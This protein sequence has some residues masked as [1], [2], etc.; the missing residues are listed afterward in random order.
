MRKPA[1]TLVFLICLSEAAENYDLFDVAN[2]VA[3]RELK[4]DWLKFVAKARG[5]CEDRQKIEESVSTNSF[6]NDIVK[7]KAMGVD[8]TDTHKVK[9]FVYWLAL[10]KEL[11]TEVE[12][13]K[14]LIDVSLDYTSDIKDL[15]DNFSW[16]KLCKR[17]Q[18]NL[19]KSK[20]G[21]RR[22]SQLLGP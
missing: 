20:D 8:G 21:K 1:L 5:R 17:V 13:P 15:H 18:D 16:E 11:R 12:P 9:E 2:E 22:K 14:W 19:K 7:E 10:Y 4:N 3:K 6:L